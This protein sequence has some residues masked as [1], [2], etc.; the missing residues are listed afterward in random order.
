MLLTAC[1]RGN[2]GK[3]TYVRPGSGASASVIQVNE[4]GTGAVQLG[5][6][7]GPVLHT[8]IWSPN[9][10]QAVFF[11]RDQDNAYLYSP[12]SRT[13]SECL[14]CGIE[15][16]R[17]VRFSP[18]GRE[19]AFGGA[20]GIFRLSLEPFT[21]VRAGPTM[22]YLEGL[23]WSP[24]LHHLALTF[25]FVSLDIYRL[26]LDDGRLVPL[27]E[28]W[29]GEFFAP[30]WSPT[31]DLIAFH[32]IADDDVRL[33]VMNPDGTGRRYV[34]SWHLEDEIFYPGDQWPPQWS[35]DGERLLFVNETPFSGVDIFVVNA[36]GSGLRN[37]TN[38]PGR[39]DYPVWSPDGRKIAFVSTRDGNSEIYVMDADGSHQVNVSNSPE[40]FDVSPQWR[41]RPSVSPLV[42]AAGGLVAA[43]LIGLI[44]AGVLRRMRARGP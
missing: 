13:L 8:P 38:S 30:E 43:L 26:D 41:P 25:A 5:E 7:L 14:T 40:T 3:I 11:L 34:A 44:V 27:T 33:E 20:E 15:R 31:G 9:G 6:E 32:A 12:D 37:L 23:S 2:A 42:Y 35:P 36:D 19:V 16:P 21:R 39:D 22:A 24:D 18:D 10:D 28:D 1:S 4:D 17:Y 29:Q